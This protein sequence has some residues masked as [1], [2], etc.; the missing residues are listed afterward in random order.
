MNQILAIRTLFSLLVH[1]E[2]Q[3][4][5]RN[6]FW[7]WKGEEFGIKIV[8]IHILEHKN[9]RST[10]DLSIQA[11]NICLFGFLEDTF[12]SKQVNNIFKGRVYEVY[13]FRRWTWVRQCQSQIAF[14]LDLIIDASSTTDRDLILPRTVCVHIKGLE[15]QDF[16]RNQ[17]EIAA[18]EGWVITDDFDT[19]I[20]HW[21]E[22]GICDKGLN[23]Y[24][25]SILGIQVLFWILLVWWHSNP[26]WLKV[27][28]A[29]WVLEV[30][31]ER[32]R[33]LS[34]WSWICS[35]CNFV[36]P[37]FRTRKTKVVEVLKGENSRN[38]IKYH[39]FVPYFLSDSE[40]VWEVA[41]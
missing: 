20:D 26:Q 4:F 1:Y 7:V 24:E 30:Q 25:C 6:V 34:K 9:D 35:Y 12:I 11:H 3:Y 22:K 21:A 37:A 19:L 29:T 17:I 32:C 23:F 2:L 38:W 33:T 5:T 10:V 15:S 14:S 8:S 18:L 16:I 41:S 31:V 27:W 28:I 39:R 36:C 40:F 13:Q